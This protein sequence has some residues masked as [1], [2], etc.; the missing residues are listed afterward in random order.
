M[1]EHEDFIPELALV[2]ERDG[3]VIANIMYTKAKL[4]D[5]DK[6]EKQVLT[7]GPIS[8]LPEYQRQGSVSYTHLDVYK[9]Q[10]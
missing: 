7:F 9:R 6:N 1:R 4:I 2:I 5:T 3:R 8:V 10:I